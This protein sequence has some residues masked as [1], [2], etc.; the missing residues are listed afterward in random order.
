MPTRAATVA[1][2]ILLAAGCGGAPSPSAPPP[3]PIVIA[4]A[5]PEFERLLDRHGVPFAPPREGKAILVN[6]PGFEAIAFEDGAP[7]IR[8]R[9]I[10]GSP[11]NPTP[12][13]DTHVSAVRFRPTWRPTPSMIASGEYEDYVR[14]PGRANPLGLAAIRLEPGMLVY[15]HDTNRRDL[16]SREARALS[17]GCVRTERWDEIAA[18]LLDVDV[19]QVHAWAEGG[20]TFDAA[21]PPV[22]VFIR[23]LTD[24]PDADGDLERHDDIYRRGRTPPASAPETLEMA[25]SAPRLCLQ[26]R[27]NA[28]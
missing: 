18:W 12:I 2:L 10:V 1:A 5:R 3:E 4:D 24:F 17:H 15:L 21:T 14:R 28:G 6:V 16:F 11:R 9:V 22:P 20:R 23:Y 8:S 19:A 7:V 25:S 26:P 27:R 13:V